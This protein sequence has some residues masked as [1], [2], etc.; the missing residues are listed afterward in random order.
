MIYQ[1]SN[2]N[3][4]K[5]LN[6]LKNIKVIYYLHS[7]F[8]YWLYLNDFSSLISVYKELQKSKYVITLVPFENNYLFKK[9]GI[10]SILMSNYISYDYDFVIPSNLSTNTILMIGRGNDKLKRFELGIISM[11]Y[12]INHIPDCEMKIIANV[13][14]V[15]NLINITKNLTLQKYVKFV[16]YTSDPEIYFKNASIHIF[17]TVSESFGYVLSETK[18]YGI[19]N[20]LLGLDYT[21]ISKGGTII[22]YDE[23][24]KTIGIEVIKILKNNKYKKKLGREARKSMKKINNELLYIRWIKLILSIFNGYNYNEEIKKL[25]KKLSIK[26]NLNTLKTQ[27]NFLKIRN[28]KFKNISCE[29]IGNFSFLEKYLR[30]EFLLKK[31]I[32]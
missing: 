25:D 17:P 1:L 3:E 23:S 21:S 27:V 28:T 24:P 8:F 18:I 19:P 4:I 11:K 6:K 29:I 13:N 30:E 12:I 20:I 16:G 10:N 22:I 14:Y 5:E 31:S 26:E 9:W 2:V 32:K 7:C 15:G